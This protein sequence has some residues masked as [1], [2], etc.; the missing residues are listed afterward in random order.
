MGVV[1]WSF[2]L[3]AVVL[4]LCAGGFIWLNRKDSTVDTKAY[5]EEYDPGQVVSSYKVEKPS[6]DETID[7]KRAL[8]SYAFSTETEE[9]TVTAEV[10]E[11]AETEEEPKEEDTEEDIV[12]AEVVEEEKKD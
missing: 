3:A 7:F 6:R 1:V 12:D 11:E 9:I 8:K 4:G 5:D 10:E 2:I